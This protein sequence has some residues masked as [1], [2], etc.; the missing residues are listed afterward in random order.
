MKQTLSANVVARNKVN[1][2]VLK[3]VPVF[4]ELLTPFVGQK[5]KLA[6]GNLSKKVRDEIKENMPQDQSVVHYWVTCSTYSLKVH[7]KVSAQVDSASCTYADV[8]YYIGELDAQGVLTELNPLQVNQYPTNYS[9]DEISALRVE[10]GLIK[11]ELDN[12]MSKLHHFGLY[13]Q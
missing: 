8:V 1:S 11:G 4:I 5:V 9:A 7:F 12:V 10:A 2:Q 3:Y 6:D 13:D